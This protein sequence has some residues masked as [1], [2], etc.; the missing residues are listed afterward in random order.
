MNM[1]SVAN[2]SRTSIGDAAAGG[3]I[4]GLIAGVAMAVYLIVVSLAAG[5]GPA[6]LL[7]RF[8][9]GNVTPAAG[10]LSHL[11]VSVVYGAVG[12]VVL[13]AVRGRV[14]APAWL[15]GLGFGLILYVVAQVLLRG[16]T[17]PM[18]QISAWHLLVAH[19]LYGLVLGWLEGRG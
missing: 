4:P 17:S 8:G 3:L 11:A 2:K 18:L 10:A 19:L 15:L 6:E 9:A 12:G 5:A 1:S 16:V 7:S 13:N 14:K